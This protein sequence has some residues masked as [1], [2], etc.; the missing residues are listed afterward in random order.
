MRS[1]SKP[2]G[3]KPR[4]AAGHGTASKEARSQLQL[5]QEHYRAI[6]EKAAVGITVTDENENIVSW[7]EF[8]EVLL[9]MNRDDLYM[10]PVSSLYPEA[11]WR[12]MRAEGLREKGIQHHMEAKMVR[13]DGETIDVDLSLTVLKD[14][15][16]NVTGSIGVMKDISFRKRMEGELWR[17]E[18]RYRTI[19]DDSAVAITVTNEDEDIVSWN[20]SAE[21]LLGMN[22]PDLLMRP[23]CSL[24]PHDEWEKIRAQN[25]KHEGVQH[26]LET[27]IIRKDEETIDV[28]LSLSVLKGPD[29]KVT[30]WIGTFTDISER[31]KA[32]EALRESEALSRGMI[33][34]AATGIYL[35][36]D[37]CFKYVNRLLEEISGYASDELVGTR[38]S[39]CVHPDDRELARAKAI[40]ALKGRSSLPYEYRIVRKDFDIV[41]VS[42]RATSI[43]FGGNR[44]ILGTLMDITENKMAEAESQEY[45]RHVE[46]LFSIST[47]VSQTLNLTDLLDSVL[48]KVLEAVEV[49]VGGIF[50]IDAEVDELVLKAYRGFSAH[51]VQRVGRMK[52]G[53]GFAGRAARSGRPVMV[54]SMSADSRFDPMILKSEGFQSLCAVSIMARGKILGVICVGSHGCRE[55]LDRDVRLLNSIANQTGVA[56]ENAQLYEQTVEI[57]FTDGLTGLYNRRYFEDQIERELARARRNE[58]PLSVLMLDLDGLKTINDGFGHHAGDALLKELG[59]IIQAN[60][61]ASDIAARLGGDEFIILAPD[62][63]SSDAC[64]IGE[65]IKSQ[66]EQCRPNI[67]GLEMAMSVSVGVASYPTHASEVTELLQSADEAVY[68]AKRGGK[69]QLCLADPS[70]SGS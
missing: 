33:E 64:T 31:K 60:T 47:T 36:Q 29:G 17:A 24:Y 34:T 37:G 6:F 56:I 46:T 32:E 19:F 70:N 45:T 59:R 39:D 49:E 7:N 42:E 48:G 26:H 12:R 44:S 11:E 18:E 52:V 65:R 50:L 68:S 3:N 10:K 57:A 55:F 43:D 5:T 67:D 61:R 27:R 38:S 58:T 8:A 28:D 66:V 40:D 15:D 25:I 13:K 69:N 30:G 9:G 1:K 54:G 35:L 41:W 2:I 14:A 20:K 63:G 51:F 53:R 4:R 62:T 21:T 16:G 22:E 23:V